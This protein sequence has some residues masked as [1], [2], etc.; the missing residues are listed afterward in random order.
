MSS[1]HSDSPVFRFE[2]FHI[3][4]DKTNELVTNPTPWNW[5]IGAGDRIAVMT[6][7]SYLRYQLILV[8]AGLVPSV[9]GR[10]IRQGV[11]GWPLGGEGGLDSKLPLKHN[12]DFVCQI[13][14]DCLRPDLF[15]IEAFWQ[16]LAEQD[17]TPSQCVR[18]LTSPQ[19]SVFFTTLTLLFA[20]DLTLVP[21]TRFLMSKAGASLRKLFLEQSQ[22]RALLTTSRNP[23]FL[24]QFCNQGLV[25]SSTGSFMFQGPLEEALIRFD[26]MP[27]HDQA[28][29]ADESL[30]DGINLQNS[31]RAMD[32]QDDIL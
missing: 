11:V 4:T 23:R 8:M 16:L 17:I 30:I 2:D 27:G 14:Q 5:S 19:K 3:R 25:L 32:D 21:K 24:R 29:E 31:D 13:Y 12:L 26:Q 7:N 10:Q 22:G 20:F 28:D 1:D 9:S 18:D 15:S 6:S